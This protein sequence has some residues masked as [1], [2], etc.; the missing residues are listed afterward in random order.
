M[1]IIFVT[2]TDSKA[3]IDD[4]YI[5]ALWHYRFAAYDRKVKIVFLHMK[6]KSNYR[7][8][9]KQIDKE[10]AS[11]GRLHFPGDRSSHVLF[12]VDTD[13]GAEGEGLNKEIA[14]FCLKHKYGLVWF[15]R[16]VEEVFLQQRVSGSE[17]KKQ[18]LT[19]FLKKNGITKLNLDLLCRASKPTGHPY[20]V[21]N[22]IAEIT[23]LVSS[24]TQ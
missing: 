2:E 23:V 8:M 6:G 10:R 17:E 15:H 7:S 13:E 24:S 5:K 12:C 16:D 21:S 22:L 20:G 14:D 4:S 19:D 1:Q 18:A 9:E 11:Y 3:R